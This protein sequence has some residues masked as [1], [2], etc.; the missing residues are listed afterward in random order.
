MPNE[1]ESPPKGAP[2]IRDCLKDWS[3]AERLSVTA[4]AAEGLLGLSALEPLGMSPNL[5]RQLL[6][7]GLLREAGEFRPIKLGIGPPVEVA[8]AMP[9]APR[10]ELL[11][12][13]QREGLLDSTVEA[14]QSVMGRRSR[15]GL[16][17]R[18]QQ[19][20]LQ[21]RESAVLDLDAERELRCSLNASFDPLWFA[22]T[23]GER[24]FGISARVLDNASYLPSPTTP[25]Y[26]WAS[27]LPV[28][29]IPPELCLSTAAQALHR[30]QAPQAHALCSQLDASTRAGISAVAQF[31]DG[32]KELALR[33]L[34]QSLSFASK[35]HPPCHGW[36]PLLAFLLATHDGNEEE[37]AAAGSRATSWLSARPPNALCKSAGRGLRTFLKYRSDPEARL[38]RLDAHQL[39]K[40]SSAWEILFL[41]LTVHAFL[42]PEPIRA[43]WCQLLARKGQDWLQLGY[44]WLGRQ[45]LV[46]ASQLHHGQFEKEYSE[47][48]LISPQPGDITGLVR[49]RQAW[50]TTLSALARLGGELNLPKTRYR[51][52]WYVDPATGSVNKPGIQEFDK[53][54]GWTTT[55]RSSFQ[56]AWSLFSDLP[57]E[58]QRALRIA[59]TPKS[60]FPHAEIL[61][62]L[63]GHQRIVD[64][65]RGG[66]RIDVRRGE[67][68]LRTREEGDQLHL[69]IDPP[70]LQA[71]MNVV[72]DGDQRL[73]IIRVTEGMQKVIDTLPKDFSVPQTDAAEA[74]NVL[75]ALADTI[76]I[77]SP[78]LSAETAEEADSTPCLRILPIG[79]AYLVEAGVRPFGSAGRFFVAGHGASLISTT[80]QGRKR[81][82]ERD[83]SAE[84]ARLARL[85]AA[86]PLLLTRS[87]DREVNR[88]PGESEETWTF[89][90]DELVE[91]LAEIRDS[92]EKCE[93]EW[94]TAGTQGLKGTVS[95]KSLRGVLRSKKGWYIVS[96]EVALDSVT[97]VSI[98][99]LSRMPSL[100]RGR[101]IRLPSG[102]FIE[103]EKRVRRVLAALGGAETVGKAKNQ[104]KFGAARLPGLQA[105]QDLGSFDVDADTELDLSRLREEESSPPAL[106]AGLQ[107]N[108]RGYQVQGFRW[109]SRLSRLNLGACLADDMGLGKTLQILSLLLSAPPGSRHIVV[110]PTSVCTNW[111]RE[112]ARFTPGLKAVEFVGPRR[113]QLLQAFR[114][115]PDGTSRLLIASY[116]LLH[117]E[118]EALGEISWHT[119]V[120]DE[121]QFIKNPSSL[122]AQAAFSLQAEH[123]IAATGTPIENHL[124]DLWS[125]FHFI[126][127]DL[128]GDW[129]SFETH[130]AKPIQ[131][132]NDPERREA[133]RDIVRPYLLRRT[134]AQVL[135][136]LPN[137]TKV[138]HEIQLSKE[139]S[140]RYALLRKQIYDKLYVG[141]VKRSNKLEVLAEITRLRRFCC[142]PQLVFPDAP[143]ESRKIDAFLDLADELRQND[144]RALVFSQY[145]DFLGLVMERLDERGMRYEHLDGSTPKGARQE[146]IDRFQA[147]DSPLFLISLKA[148]GLGINLTAADYVI[149]LD[150]WWNPAVG[151]QATDRAH[152]MGQKQAVT[153]YDFVTKDTI[154]E[155]ILKLHQSKRGLANSLLEGGEQVGRLDAQELL[156]WLETSYSLELPFG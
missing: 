88:A 106:P 151:A 63:C 28:L 44:L 97:S 15:A 78:H 110:A 34:D 53:Q 95:G 122:R 33:L 112:C 69:E 21:K 23:W 19:G 56:D 153:V 54:A 90:A 129:R 143:S 101:F 99:E 133:L 82:T 134:K 27:S 142:H 31:Q 128:L 25:L 114:D 41:G 60:P 84:R 108:L 117:E 13:A 36:T 67:C 149:H 137:L 135:K 141:A 70:G 12:L 64:G 8:Y 18:L 74:L 132:E 138:R 58:D 20:N 111:L 61:G 5:L 86:C 43:S 35:K 87:Q 80:E 75:G 139:D 121:A 116:T 125:L 50:Q 57:V 40:D 91:L 48:K 131:R 152:R 11:R 39:P 3:A 118:R 123:R 109:L 72:R 24:R 9:E 77:K 140:L 73:V 136:E 47:S 51:L 59:V 127:P 156:A 94:P 103:V 124:G 62:M 148:G 16:T 150:P 120:L 83:F 29:E 55:R 85:V 93:F 22:E 147:G 146:R 79:G 42:E 81:R 89:S 2:R 6:D 65:A 45:A 144:H 71:G 105:L 98:A 92:G 145:V 155:D 46:L 49:V 32:Q 154:E 68:T 30:L 26:G 104:L 66:L 113:G 4:L 52:E 37:Q 76:T 7:A 115:P 100:A 102:D 119:A 10:Q 38:K 17:R 130:F 96:G 126:T 14:A 107:A 1:E